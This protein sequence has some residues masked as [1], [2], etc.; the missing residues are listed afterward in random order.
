MFSNLCRLLLPVTALTLL[1]LGGCTINL[2]HDPSGPTRTDTKSIDLDKSEL[3]RV[4][5]KMGAGELNVRGG[6]TKLMDAEFNYDNPRMRPEVRYDGAGFRGHLQV[7]EPSNSFHGGSR[8]YRWDLRFND[9]KP[10]DMEV[11][12]GAGEGRLDLGSL[13]LRSLE[14]HMGVGELRL[15]LRGSPKH[16]YDVNI[17]GGV[18]EATVYLPESVGVSADA[19]GGIGG[20][21][22]RGLQKRDGRYVNDAYGHSKTTIHLEIRGGIGAIN[23]VG[24]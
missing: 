11:H 24:G 14:V 2:D 5:L 13:S 20:I 23:L 22:A 17:H 6:S 15:D 9:E 16:D 18:G 21:N 10:L 3:V 12:F 19:K 7:E 1:V 4:V 8:K